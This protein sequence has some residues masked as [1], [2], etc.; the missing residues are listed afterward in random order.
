MYRR[1][2]AHALFLFVALFGVLKASLSLSALAKAKAAGVE[3]A[4]TADGISTRL[5]YD[6]LVLSRHPGGSDFAKR[7][8]TVDGIVYGVRTFIEYVDAPADGLGASDTNH[9]TTDYKTLKLPSRIP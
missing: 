7:Q 4:N 5:S 2:R 9:I 8:S 6:S 3:L 1:Y